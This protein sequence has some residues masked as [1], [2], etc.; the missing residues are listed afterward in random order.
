MK[1]VFV[2]LPDGIWR[3]IN[4]D[5]KKN[6]GD[7]ESEIIRNIVIA[8]LSHRGYFINSQGYEDTAEIHQKLSAYENMLYAMLELLEEKGTMTIS[9]WEKKMKKNIAKSEYR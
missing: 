8:Y 1:R 4:K 6:M 2:S 5:F 3:I 9:D 7:S